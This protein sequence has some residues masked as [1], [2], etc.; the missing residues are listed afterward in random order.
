MHRE[1][2]LPTQR[3][4]Q[5]LCTW[6]RD[7]LSQQS[8]IDFYMVSA[9]ILRSMFHVRD[10]E[11]RT[12]DWSPRAG[13]QLALDRPPGPM[14]TC[15][16]RRSYRAIWGLCRQGC[17][18]VRWRP[19]QEASLPPQCSNLRSFES[20]CNVG[21]E[22][23]CDIVGTFRRPLQS[24][25]APRNDSAPNGLCPSCCPSLRPCLPCKNV[26]KTFA[27]IVPSLFRELQES[28]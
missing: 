15:R 16:A 4:A 17:N 7:S 27:D 19:G 1:R 11:C 12:V 10:K 9:Y 25:G 2:F 14:Q 21:E 23:T 24:F 8:L 13:L 18:Q 6:C 5:V 26:R 3:C 20:E 22:R 28:T